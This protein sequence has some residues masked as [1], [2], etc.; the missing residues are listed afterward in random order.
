MSV[1]DKRKQSARPAL[2]ALQPRLLREDDAGIYVGHSGIFLRNL[3]CQDM[4]RIAGGKPI[5]GPRWISINLGRGQGKRPSVRYSIE[6][7]DEWI[8]ALQEAAR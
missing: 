7:L 2:V 6:A 3:R 1:P 5:E 8:D 4:R